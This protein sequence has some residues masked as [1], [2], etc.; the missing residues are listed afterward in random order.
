MLALLSTLALLVS[1][2][3]VMSFG[4]AS[5]KSSGNVKL[6][7]QGASTGGDHEKWIAE[8]VDPANSDWRLKNAENGLYLT[9]ADGVL[10]LTE[11][12]GSDRAQV[13]YFGDWYGT[14]WRVVN[15]GTGEYLALNGGSG[16]LADKD[17]KG[18]A[19][20]LI[21]ISTTGVS[22]GDNTGW[23]T[24]ITDGK[25]YFI[26]CMN[27]M[28]SDPATTPCI[29]SGVAGEV[30]PVGPDEPDEPVNE[31][32]LLTKAE[33]TG[34]AW[35]K[36]IAESVDQA[37]G[38]WRLKNADSGLYLAIEQGKLIL[39]EKDETAKGQVWYFGDWYGAKWRVV[40]RGT[41]EYLVLNGGS[42]ILADKDFK[43]SADH[44]ISIS[45]TGVSVGSDV[46]WANSIEDGKAYFIFCRD[47][48]GADADKTR[49][50]LSGEPGEPAPGAH[51]AAGVTLIDTAHVEKSAAERWTFESADPEHGIWRIR[52][53]RDG[54]YLTIVD[55]ALALTERNDKD[56]G[57][58]WA[59]SAWAELYYWNVVNVG[60]GDHL[61]LAGGSGVLPAA[62]FIGGG[63]DLITITAD[64][65]VNG[66]GDGVT[67]IAEG[68]EYYLHCRWLPND[69]PADETPC[70]LSA[71]KGLALDL[72]TRREADNSD[73]QRWIAEQT[74]DG[75]WRFKNKATGLYLSLR[76][77][78]AV[79]L[80]IADSYAQDWELTDNWGYKWKMRENNANVFFA[81]FQSVKA[82]LPA[83]YSAQGTQLVSFAVDDLTAPVSELTAGTAYYIYNYH[84][85]DPNGTGANEKCLLVAKTQTEPEDPDA[86]LS[87]DPEEKLIVEEGK[88]Y[89]PKVVDYT[90]ADRSGSQKWLFEA[91]E[92]TNRY[93]IRSKAAD[94]YLTVVNGQVVLQGFEDKPGQ[95]W[96]LNNEYG[97]TYSIIN[98]ATH[99]AL[100]LDMGSVPQM[101]A[102]DFSQFTLI[103]LARNTTLI[104]PDRSDAPRADKAFFLYNW[105]CRNKDDNGKYRGGILAA[106][107]IECFPGSEEPDEPMPG[108]DTA[109]T[110]IEADDPVSVRLTP[111]SAVRKTGTQIWIFHRRDIDPVPDIKGAIDPNA[112]DRGADIT[113]GYT[114][115][116]Q[117]TG[118][119][120]TDNGGTV[121]Q[122]P[123]DGSLEQVWTVEHYPSSQYPLMRIMRNVGT[124]R[125]LIVSRDVP[126]LF[127]PRGYTADS[128]EW[129]EFLKQYGG[130]MAGVSTVAIARVPSDLLVQSVEIEDGKGYYLYTTAHNLS[131]SLLEADGGRVPDQTT[132]IPA[133]RDDQPYHRDLTY[134]ADMSADGRTIGGAFD[135][136]YDAEIVDGVLVGQ[137]AGDMNTYGIGFKRL[138]SD[139]GVNSLT[140]R[141][142]IP[143]AAVGYTMIGLRMND[144]TDVVKDQTGI[145]LY[146]DR[147]GRVGI[148]YAGTAETVTWRPTGL[149][150]AEFRRVTVEDDADRNVIRLYF[151]NDEGAKTL[152]A[153][154]TLDRGTAVLRPALQVGE[155]EIRAVERSYGYNFY[156]NGYMSVTTYQ[157]Y[158]VEITEVSAVVPQYSAVAFPADEP[159]KPDDP[160]D[161]IRIRGVLLDGDGKPLSGHTVSLADGKITV[162]TDENGRFVLAD[163]PMGAAKL[164]V[165]DAA[166]VLVGETDLY[167]IRGEK[168]R[169][170]GTNLT[171]AKGVD[172][173]ELTVNVKNGQLILGGLA[174][175]TP[176]TGVPA[177]PI[178]AAVLVCAIACGAVLML[179]R[180]A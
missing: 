143:E 16:V 166:G 17:F 19:D 145:R 10:T 61:G 127:D 42:G 99:N 28:G 168:T 91:V 18:G 1:L 24:T 45:T 147:D 92:G 8:S 123:A 172:S 136:L 132:D 31:A 30:G 95:Q 144:Y 129:P 78:E 29:L 133:A 83:D 25:A 119:M 57:Q 76:G 43:G 174:P 151:D 12:N 54:L 126:E 34:E 141:L 150:F 88:F 86:G 139:R 15:R 84:A 37:N 65:P 165:R 96:E 148:K 87:G 146:I 72:V 113:V 3:S 104:R 177:A 55:G 23:E 58:L 131:S 155:G 90:K 101:G 115:Q 156:R 142:K 154:L 80:S 122:M 170:D 180:R 102:A 159:D 117:E 97:L 158:D 66:L 44:L 128:D 173:V 13:W 171:V 111:I 94:L 114:V 167:L 175:D 134:R 41:G 179:R 138:T 178:A 69:K 7:A 103:G 2:L 107:D 63:D 77:D 89:Q 93:R 26:F 169:L 81:C 46:G 106:T 116:N 176:K 62:S 100:H 121:V 35:E 105:S 163:V 21:S 71:E 11:K 40:N 110:P 73:V 140:F 153:S 14:K 4:I 6:I 64:A 70:V 5:A 67:A 120:L 82:I 59:L 157:A 36:W 124:G 50:I 162:L 164:T 9:I 152:V 60:T 125:Q 49:C 108:Q 47:L 79:Q 109:N 22:V 85:T 48:S 56:N 39:T 118:L 149:A 38:D 75:L 53:V 160:A 32:F 98:V 52:N 130:P 27:L 112:A 161:K 51:R 74:A 33:S 135:L 137:P 20:H 68:T